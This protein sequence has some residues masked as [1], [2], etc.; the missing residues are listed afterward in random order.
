MLEDFNLEDFSILQLLPTKFERVYKQSVLKK[1]CNST[2]ESSLS[3]QTDSNVTRLWSRV[4][5][6]VLSL[7]YVHRATELV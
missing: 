7:G 6:A 5:W 3:L 4:T 1:E 2:L